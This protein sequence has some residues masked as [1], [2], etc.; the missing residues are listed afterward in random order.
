MR[1][2]LLAFALLAPISIATGQGSAQAA[3]RAFEFRGNTLGQPMNFMPNPCS[4]ASCYSFNDHI[5]ESEVDISYGVIDGRMEGV[6]LFFKADEFDDLVTA[7]TAKWGKPT[8]VQS[9]PYHT[10]GGLKTTNTILTWSFAQGNLNLRH[11]GSSITDGTAAIY[12]TR[13]LRAREAKETE[14]AKAAQSDM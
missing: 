3:K 2:S 14:K 7:F 4:A 12:T 10:Q 9:E 1:F 11:F 5:G 13:Y 8:R 6:T